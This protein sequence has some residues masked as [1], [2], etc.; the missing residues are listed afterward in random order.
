LATLI[1][2]GLAS[3][4]SRQH[5]VIAAA[6]EALGKLLPRADGYLRGVIIDGMRTLIP[7]L[8][9]LPLTLGL[10]DALSSA[11][12]ALDAAGIHDVARE[13]GAAMA[14]MEARKGR[15]RAA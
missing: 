5:V 2:I 9:D 3:D 10:R 6:M 4:E 7:A 12:L 8:S 13:I 14:A 1:T 15:L 11:R